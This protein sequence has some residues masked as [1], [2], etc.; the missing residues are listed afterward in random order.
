MKDAKSSVATFVTVIVLNVVII[1]T[2]IWAI[3]AG[4]IP[5][6]PG[7]Q[8]NF[9]DFLRILGVGVGPF[10]LLSAIGIWVVGVVDREYN[11]ISMGFLKGTQIFIGLLYVINYGGTFLTK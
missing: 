5:L 2:H 8:T 10:A 6:P 7:T 11:T 1:I 3:L 9:W 4:S